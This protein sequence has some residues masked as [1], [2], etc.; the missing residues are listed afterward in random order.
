MKYILPNKKILEKESEFLDDDKYYNL[1]KM[2]Y[3]KDFRDNY[4]IPLGMDKNKEKYY[5]DLRNISGMFISGETGSG[6]SVFLHSVIVSLLLKN[7]PNDLKF[8]FYDERKIELNNY[9]RLPHYL[10]SLYSFD[11]LNNIV[12][13]INDRKKCLLKREYLI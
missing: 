9:K 11:D 5:L 12:T 3:H 10:N 8:I 7:S 4:V 2:I 13:L 6:K 1:S